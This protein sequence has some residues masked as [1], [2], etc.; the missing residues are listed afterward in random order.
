MSVGPNPS[1]LCMC[2]CG[3][4]APIAAQSSTRF[5]WVAGEPVRYVAGHNRAG[6]TALGYRVDDETGCWIWEGAI[7]SDGYGSIRQRGR[8]LPAHRWMY[9]Q[10]RGPV[11]D[12]LQLD[13][14]C[15]NRACVNP[16]HLEPVTGQENRRR[17]S[18]TK[19]TVEAVKAIHAGRR[20]GKTQRE[21]AR[22][23]G[24]AQPTISQ[25]LAG[26]WWSEVMS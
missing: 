20:A 2:G 19:L 18:G 3:A 11:P 17:G 9:E 8:S 1:G 14:L 10:L 5:G 26:K 23:H 21:L 7:R 15:R 22:E 24:V 16:D 25:I 13:H 4:K 6:K 12:G